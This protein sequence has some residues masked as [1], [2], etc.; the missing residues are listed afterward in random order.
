MKDLIREI[1]NVGVLILL[2]IIGTIL[3][4]SIYSPTSAR[5][6]RFEVV[7]EPN[8]V[9]TLTRDEYME[10]LRALRDPIYSWELP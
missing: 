2:I 7:K 1:L 10:Y 6:L 4:S 5:A 3:V 9:F 8:G